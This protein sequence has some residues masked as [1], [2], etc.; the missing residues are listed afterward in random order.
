MRT[1][2]WS[3]HN[4]HGNLI[5]GGTITIGTEMSIVNV[6]EEIEDMFDIRL[7]DYHELRLKQV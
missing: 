2:Q 4:A 3:V 5:Q 7:G 1:I 6:I